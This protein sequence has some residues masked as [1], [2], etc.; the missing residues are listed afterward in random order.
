MK[1]RSVIYI[2]VCLLAAAALGVLL[3]MRAAEKPAPA[4]PTP[5]PTP[6]TIM[7][8]VGGTELAIDSEA[9]ELSDLPYS[10]DALCAAKDSFTALKSISLGSSVS[11]PA[12]KA[13]IQRLRS[14][15]PDIELH[16]SVNIAGT[17]YDCS[18]E[19]IS[20]SNATE[21]SSYLDTLDAFPALREICISDTAPLEPDTLRTLSESAPGVRLKAVFELFGQTVSS[22]D[23]S[24][25]F[26]KLD[27]GE[28]GLETLRLVLPHLDCTY[29]QISDCGIGNEELAALRD[30]FPERNIVWRVYIYNY[31]YMTNCHRVRTVHI[32]SVTSEVLKYCTEV[33]YLDLGH[34][35][36]INNC[37]FVAYM[38]HL[39]SAILG[40][41]AI[42]DISPLANCKELQ[43]LELHRSNIS[44]ISVL[45]GLTSLEYLNIGGMPELS[46]LS[47][48]FNL[49][50]L[51]V[52]R[53]VSDPLI[54]SEQIAELQEHLPDTTFLLE[55]WAPHMD[56]WRYDDDGNMVEWYARLREQM[57]YDD[58]NAYTD[59]R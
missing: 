25:I 30:E 12:D 2:I 5:E 14:A 22:G 7:I 3:F 55:G 17:E 37:D 48:L 57:D 16:F 32:D 59:I 45:S 4:E 56:G 35:L 49:T 44:D 1:K 54:S 28:A 52:I 31:P 51:K 36:Y 19:T 20:V 58:E 8:D 43:F 50:G 29:F 26:D 42:T 53:I 27:I 10:F 11:Y 18:A 34:N 40:L 38:P 39:Q 6:E 33:R 24:I 13:N 46:D 21:L 23:E 15:Y 41:T 9:L 47:P